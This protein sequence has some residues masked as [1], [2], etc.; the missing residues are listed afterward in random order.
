LYG[1]DKIPGKSTFSRN[2]TELSAANIMNETLGALVKEAHAGTVVYH[3]SRDSTAVEAREAQKGGGSPG[4]AGNR[5]WT[6]YKLH[7]N[8]S[9]T[10]FP[11]SAF[12]SG[13]NVYDSQLAI[14]LEKMTEGKV[15]FCYGLMDAA[16]DSSSSDILCPNCNAKAVPPTR[17]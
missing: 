9:D 11:F 8:V 16:Y 14:P 4:E 12:V 13:A 10:G 17:K 15:F 3:A 1:F 7:L 5:F 6:G 2:F